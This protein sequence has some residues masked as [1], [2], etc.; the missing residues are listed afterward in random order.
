MDNIFSNICDEPLIIPLKK[1]K[2][3]GE[4]GRG[5]YTEEYLRSNVKKHTTLPKNYMQ[6]LESVEVAGA[7]MVTLKQILSASVIS[8]ASFII[9]ALFSS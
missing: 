1:V 8:G 2:V 9:P 7:V 6:C 4:I 5:A 3:R